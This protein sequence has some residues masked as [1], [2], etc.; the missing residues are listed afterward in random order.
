[1][2]GPVTWTDQDGAD[3]TAEVRELAAIMHDARETGTRGSYGEWDL[4]SARAA[5]RWFRG[6]RQREER[7]DG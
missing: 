2:S 6:R 3:L 4:I 7:R 5:L 1:V